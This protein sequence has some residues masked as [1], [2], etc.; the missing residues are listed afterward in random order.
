[1][2]SSISLKKQIFFFFEKTRN[3]KFFMRF[4]PGDHFTKSRPASG[5]W[6][7]ALQNFNQE[8]FRFQIIF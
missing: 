2:F 4:N 6:R 8:K 7:P 1:M 5:V 3:F